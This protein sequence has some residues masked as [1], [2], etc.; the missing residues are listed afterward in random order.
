VPLDQIEDK[1]EGEKE[2]GFLDHVEELR[3]RLIRALLAILVFTIIAFFC[4]DI[5]FGI[6]ILGPAKPDF[7]TYKV[8]CQL[9]AMWNIPSLCID[10]LNFSLQSRNM[11]GQ[12]MMH[13]T[14][15]FVAGIIVAFPYVCWELWSFVKPGLYLKEKN[16]TSGVVF[17]VA[18]LF[19]LGVLF[20]YYVI[21]PL[22][23]NFLANYQLDPTILNQFDI[24]SYV[25]TLI[26]MVLASG[27]MFQLPMVMWVLTKMGIITPTFMRQY[28]RH[29]I[30]V[31][32]LVAAF[33][34][35]S[36]DIFSQ[37]LVAF[38]LYLLYEMSIFVSAYELRKKAIRD[39]AE[40]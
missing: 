39:A 2:M 15:S 10:H 9:G 25:S 5:I 38:P 27:L 24:T 33:I 16:A 6:L 8:F 32:L 29:A 3:W 19:A 40:D 1:P 34:T 4:K 22:S 30:V 14:S 12:F 17:Y 36:P 20:G 31:I 23:I 35:P 7:F 18:L 28:R 21:S 26:F 37:I 11:T 13:I